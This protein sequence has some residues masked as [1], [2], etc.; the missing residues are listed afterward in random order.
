MSQEGS[1][2]LQKRDFRRAAL[3][4]EIS[5]QAGNEH[6]NLLYNLACVYS[7]SRIKKKALDYLGQAVK[8][9]FNN[10]ELIKKDKDLDFIRN[11]KEFIE[12]TRELN[13]N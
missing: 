10:L 8:K 5:L 7:L 13:D 9:G 12:I 4:F 11:E 6:P 2:Y 1:D 3:S